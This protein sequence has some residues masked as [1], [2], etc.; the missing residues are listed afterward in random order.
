[1]N[2]HELNLNDF[3]SH[4]LLP[5]RKVTPV[6]MFMT[7]MQLTKWA[8]QGINPHVV[9]DI[10]LTEACDSIHL[11]HASLQFPTDES[12]SLHINV[13]VSYYCDLLPEDLKEGPGSVMSSVKIQ[14]FPSTHD[15]GGE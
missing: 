7:K 13:N 10:K 2:P 5:I 9:N 12:R 15:C 11:Y 6:T 14:H 3:F 1:M 8:L 4:H